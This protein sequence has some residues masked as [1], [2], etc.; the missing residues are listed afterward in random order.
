MSRI[1]LEVSNIKFLSNGSDGGHVYVRGR[2]EFRVHGEID[3]YAH[4]ENKLME[5]EFQDRYQG[6]SVRF[7]SSRWDFM[8]EIGLSLWDVDEW[9]FV[10]ECHEEVL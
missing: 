5:R 8:K 9:Q 4:F 6:G 10:T 3:V 1:T 7:S 2:G